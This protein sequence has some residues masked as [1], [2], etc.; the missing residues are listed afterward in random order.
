[1]I[2]IAYSILPPKEWCYDPDFE[3]TKCNSLKSCFKSK[4]LIPPRYIINMSKNKEK[5]I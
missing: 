5:I 1:M 4:K 3:L 2:L